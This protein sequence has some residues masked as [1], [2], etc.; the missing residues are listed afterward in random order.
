MTPNCIHI[1]PNGEQCQA[2]PI[3]GRKLCWFHDPEFEARRKAASSEGG[4][5]KKAAWLNLPSIS[6]R[7]RPAICDLNESVLNM[8]LTN[9]IDHH[10][11]NS[12]THL[13]N[14]QLRALKLKGEEVRIRNLELLGQFGMAPDT[15]AAP[16][17]GPEPAAGVDGSRV[18]LR[19]IDDVFKVIEDTTN[20]VLKDQIHPRHANAIGS[21]ADA[22][23]GLISMELAERKTRF[24]AAEEN[25]SGRR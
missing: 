22:Q 1:L 7:T 8:L 25:K 2:H 19:S 3:V 16:D 11:A 5:A 20:A 24:E 14:I 9:E 18:A 21:A 6:L 4:R 10:A 13:G 23:L 17:V 12:V 15:A